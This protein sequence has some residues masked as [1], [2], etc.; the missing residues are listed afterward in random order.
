VSQA[1]NIFYFWF[2]ASG[3]LLAVQIDAAINPGNSG[4]P[5]LKGDKVPGKFFLLSLNNGIN[6]L[7]RWLGL[8]FKAL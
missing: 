6:P 8:P 4:G 1:F 5:V 2:K 3:H 7:R